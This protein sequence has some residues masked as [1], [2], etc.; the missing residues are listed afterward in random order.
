MS[1]VPVPDMDEDPENFPRPIQ[2]VNCTSVTD[3]GLL[4]YSYK[5]KA[6]YA[7]K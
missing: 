5:K 6:K 3:D 4:S 2:F 7:L 1:L